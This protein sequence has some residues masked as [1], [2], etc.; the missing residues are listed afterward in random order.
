VPPLLGE[1]EPA[2]P[3]L[4]TV[5]DKVFPGVKLV[6]YEIAAPPPPPPAEDPGLEQGE[7]AAPPDPPPPPTT[8]ILSAVM[9]DGIVNVPLDVKT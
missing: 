1:E 2:V 9:L 4:P 7:D 5:T 6:K 3:P 8:V